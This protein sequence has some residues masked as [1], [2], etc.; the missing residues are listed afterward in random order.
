MIMAMTAFEIFGVLKLDTS[1][2]E[3]ELESAEKG[4]S[5]FGSAVSKGLGTAAKAGIAAVGAAT[6]AAVG[7]TTK[8]VQAGSAFDQAMGTVAAT[9]GKTVDELDE[10]IGEADTA[11]G[12]FS[13]TLR[14]FAI[15]MGQNTV[16]SATQAAQALNYMALAGYDTQKSMNMLPTVLSMAAAGSMD[17][18]QA[19]DMVTDTQKALGL[20]FERTALMAD[21]FAKAASTGNT[22]VQMLGEAF[23]RVGGLARELNGG[24]ITLSDG[25]ELYRDKVQELEIAFVAMA[26]AGVKG[27]EAGTHMRNMLLKLSSPTEKGGTAMHALNVEVFDAEGRMRSLKDIYG[28][29][30]SHMEDFRPVIAD[31]R[32]EMETMSDS[33]ATDK[34]KELSVVFGDDILALGDGIEGLSAGLDYIENSLSKDDDTLG[35]I[36]QKAKI[37]A[38]S[39]LFNTRDLASAEALLNSI[40]S[41]WDRIGESVSLAVVDGKGAADEMSKTKLDNL[42]GDLQLFNSALEAA[43]IAI[44]DKLSP[45]LRSFVQLG[46]EGLQEMTSGFQEGGLSGMIEAMGETLSKG[47]QMIIDKLPEVMNAGMALLGALGQGLID[48]LPAIIAAATNIVNQLAQ[49]LISALP[50]LAP[51]MLQILM[52]IGQAVLDNAPVILDAAIKAVAA[53]SQGLGEALPTLIPTIV[54]ALVGLIQ[55]ILDNIDIII[56]AALAIIKGLAD[57]IIA[58]LPILID[59]IPEVIHKLVEAILANLAEIIV[60][61]IEII[62][63]LIN[64]IIDAIPQLVAMIPEIILAIVTALFDAMPRIVMSG[65]DLIVALGKGLMD[66]VPSLLALIP[67]IILEVV[68]VFAEQREKLAYAGMEMIMQISDGVKQK[69]GEALTWGKDLIANFIEGIKS[70]FGDVKGVLASLGKLIASLIGFSEPDI[71]PLSNFHTYAPDMMELFAKGIKDN[72]NLI[73]DQLSDSFAFGDIPQMAV[74]GVGSIGETDYNDNGSGES[75]DIITAITDALM[76]MRLTVNIGNRPIEAMITSATQ[77]INYKTGGR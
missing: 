4:T 48:N 51:A 14:E 63:A 1:D 73:H 65:M 35:A 61:G 20:D 54:S 30:T 34:L 21:E 3:K 44:N 64:G 43:Y 68:R 39:E 59:A 25:T 12:H 31:I 8:A 37:G 57:G 38:I 75:G 56:Q 55:V 72:E 16:F 9:S 33:D 22:D 62:L 15:F 70:K 28:D 66:A 76:N 49:G 32:K 46:A 45:T 6:T 53:F 58:A 41:D 60:A 47:L 27:A 77:N 23:L 40:E 50:A 42:L 10:S 74:A 71:G 67:Q 19:S 2:Y 26:D 52:G 11:Y 36:T 24:Y 69:I 18:A 5:S 29:L 17:L 13:G 7:F